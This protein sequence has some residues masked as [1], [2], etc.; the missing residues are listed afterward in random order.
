MK[1]FFPNALPAWLLI[2]LIASLAI[3]QVVFL[4]TVSQ[5]RAE[6]DQT[7][8]L[9]RLN[10]RASW[11]VKLLYPAPE[12]ERE[13]IAASLA[14]SAFVVNVSPDAFVPS[15]IAS[16]DTL[17]ELEDILVGRLARYGVVDARV[18]LDPAQTQPAPPAEPS[19]AARSDLGEVE[20]DLISLASDFLTTERY[21]VS[22]QFKDGQWVNFV[23][24]VTPIPPMLSPESMPTYIAAALIVVLLAFWAVSK[25]TSPYLLLESAVTRLGADLRSP[26]LVETGA[27]DYKSA[28]RAV[29]A[30][31]QQL[32]A[33]VE[34]REHLAAALAHD[35]RTPITRMRL[36]L[37]MMRKSDLRE[38][39]TRDIA[40]VERIAASVLDFAKLQAG[41]G[42]LEPLD[43]VS[44]VE[45]LADE[46]A[47]VTIRSMP[48]S[49]LVCRAQPEALRRCLR[50]L[51]ENGVKY[52][53][54]VTLDVASDHAEM[55]IDISDQGRGI[56][57]HL[58]ETVFRPFQRVETSRNPDTGGFGLGL[59]IARGLARKM[60][61][62]VTLSNRQGSGLRAR[63]TLPL[64][65]AHLPGTTA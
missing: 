44:F 6:S 42:D 63:V 15:P 65:P 62:D 26:P 17:A 19:K 18:R 50:N 31:Q 1:R 11:L 48:A 59:T 56:P 51:V 24:P 54:L 41:E 61:G 5:D 25:L 13:R 45:T 8:E 9:Y 2:I 64:A 34:D 3:L 12:N 29:N 53:K 46:Y 49:R 35:L 23:S 32:L 4:H 16:D 38:A 57:E 60:G 22:L 10:E 39:L 52:G 27:A 20:G 7:A 58:L 43:I 30:M 36:R 40:A 37:E 14:N 47:E 21:T 33:Y 55:H 28:A